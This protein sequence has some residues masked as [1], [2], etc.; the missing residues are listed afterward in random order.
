M[1]VYVGVGVARVCGSGKG[2]CGSGKGVWEWQ[3]CVGVARVCGCGWVY[4]RAWMYACVPDCVY[5][6]VYV[7]A[8]TIWVNLMSSITRFYITI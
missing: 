8:A 7:R 1:C 2:V 5:M 6:C 3:G 4:M